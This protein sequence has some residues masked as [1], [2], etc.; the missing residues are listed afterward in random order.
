MK[1]FVTENLK[2]EGEILDNNSPDFTEQI[3][4]FGVESAPTILI[5]NEDKKEIFRGNEV[6][7]L[8]EF[9]TKVN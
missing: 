9:L 3:Q 1:S 4:K 6:E 8:K 5:F 2:F 7:N